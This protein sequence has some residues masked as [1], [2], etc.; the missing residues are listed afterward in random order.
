M[1]K[2]KP[3]IKNVRVGN[4]SVAIWENE[5]IGKQGPFTAYSVTMQ[6]SYKDEN[7]E[8][9]NSDFINERDILL[10]AAALNKSFWEIRNLRDSN[11]TTE[12]E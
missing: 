3:P 10:C 8:Y 5:R 6:S 12:E 1:A 7:G 2:S 11:R 4:V 9:K